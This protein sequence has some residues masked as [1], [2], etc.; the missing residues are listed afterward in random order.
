MGPLSGKLRGTQQAA[1][2]ALGRLTLTAEDAALETEKLSGVL[3]TPASEPEL[4]H[5]LTSK[6]PGLDTQALVA[7]RQAHKP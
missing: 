2:T 6:W 1:C 4:S 3:P 7:H 5:L